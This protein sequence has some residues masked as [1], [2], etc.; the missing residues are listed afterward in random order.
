[1]KVA[2]KK[3]RQKADRDSEWEFEKGRQP[4]E[5][6]RSELKENKTH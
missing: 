5:L 6:T 2:Q 1:M 3:G 4:I